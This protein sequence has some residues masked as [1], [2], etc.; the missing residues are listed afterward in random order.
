MVS[1]R[2]IPLKVH[3]VFFGLW[4]LLAGR[5][6]HLYRFDFSVHQPE[7]FNPTTKTTSQGFLPTCTDLCTRVYKQLACT[8]Y[9]INRGWL[10]N[11]HTHTH[12]LSYEPWFMEQLHSRGT[13]TVS[14]NESLLY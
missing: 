10:P 14:V 2:V 13:D 5:V 4:M 6:G 8:K 11:K 12:T 3:L 7:K 1:V 9:R